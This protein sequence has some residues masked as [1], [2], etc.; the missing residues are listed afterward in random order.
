MPTF[1]EMEKL[2]SVKHLQTKFY[3]KTIV[4]GKKGIKI[5][6][7]N[8][9]VFLPA[10]QVRYTDGRLFSIPRN[11]NG[12]RADDSGGYWTNTENGSD[13][14]YSFIFYTY[15]EGRYS[16]G[17]ESTITAEMR[18]YGLCVRCVKE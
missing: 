11:I 18:N 12:A 5:G 10:A 7:G 4:N 15:S 13:N 8:N 9:T 2:T 1:E 17:Y 6:N 16:Y 3:S 14:A